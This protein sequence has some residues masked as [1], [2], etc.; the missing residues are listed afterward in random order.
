MAKYDITQDAGEIT[1]GLRK[2]PK[3]DRVPNN[4]TDSDTDSD[5]LV[6]LNENK[7]E[8]MN[9]DVKETLQHQMMIQTMISLIQKRK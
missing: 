3:M 6:T 1:K 2:I 8:E 7:E 9:V 4:D 5:F